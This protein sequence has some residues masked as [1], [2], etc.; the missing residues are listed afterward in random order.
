MIGTAILLFL[1]TAITDV[2]NSAPAAS[3]APIAIGLL[4]VAIGMAWDTDAGCAINPA[5][6]LGPRLAEFL[7]GYRT[8]FKDQ[9]GNFYFW[10]PIVAP[11]VGGIVGTGLYQVLI[12][13]FLPAAQE[14]EEQTTQASPTEECVA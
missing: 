7:T 10:V 4:V 2:R 11:V 12:G 3:V 5:R 1:I 6:D 13:R 14:H 8:A 9:Y